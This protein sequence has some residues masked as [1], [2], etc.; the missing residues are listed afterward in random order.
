MNETPYGP[1]PPVHSCAQVC[2]CV[3]CLSQSEYVIH[4]VP[5]TVITLQSTAYPLLL[6]TPIAVK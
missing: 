2:V 4:A 6:A 3:L 5:L 1:R